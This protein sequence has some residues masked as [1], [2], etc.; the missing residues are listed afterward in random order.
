MLSAE[1]FTSMLTCKI[2][3]VLD[4]QPADYN[5]IKKKNWFHANM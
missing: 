1:I 2:K 4:S 3:Y 5:E